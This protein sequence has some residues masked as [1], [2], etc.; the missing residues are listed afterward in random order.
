MASGLYNSVWCIG[1]AV[2]PIYSG[3]IASWGFI[4]TLRYFNFVKILYLP[5]FVLF[6]GYS[7]KSMFQINKYNKLQENEE[8]I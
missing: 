6:S 8:I 4:N 2:G 7:I 5:I 1:N 3:L